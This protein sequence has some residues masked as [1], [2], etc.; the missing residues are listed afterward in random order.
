[1]NA[2]KNRFFKAAINRAAQLAGKP[3]RLVV[4][5]AQLSI[6][7]HYTPGASLT[8]RTLR[9]QFL[10]I[11]R[12]VKA[13]LQGSYKMKSLRILIALI[14]AIIYFIN[15]VDLIPDLI[16]GIGLA[17]DLA[18]LTWVYRAAANEINS[19]KHWETTFAS[20][21]PAA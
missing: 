9:E 13:H 14:A 16:F 12:M 3:G 18:V 21:R 6:K 15:P 10:L 17:D 2:I 11:S 19:F 1:M 4:L 20:T 7:L 8:I 5:L